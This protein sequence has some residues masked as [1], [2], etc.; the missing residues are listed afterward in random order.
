LEAD[1]YHQIDRPELALHY[2]RQALH[3][4]EEKGNQPM[5]AQAASFI[6]LELAQRHEFD[7]SQSAMQQAMA[8]LGQIPERQ[9]AYSQ[10]LVLLR[11][12]D[13]AAEQGK[14]EQAESRYAEAQRLAEN[15]EEQPLPLLK[16]LRAR[17]AS[18]ARVG[19]TE[20]AQADLKRAIALIERYRSGVSEQ[21]NRSDFF[22]ASQDVFDQMIQLEAHDSGQSI[23]A[24]NL[25]EQARARTLLDDLAAQANTLATPAP[26]PSS[27]AAQRSANPLTLAEIRRRLPADLTLLSY[28]V[29]RTGTLI[30]VVSRDTFE[31]KE[32]AATTDTLDRLVQG[33]VSSLKDR[34]SSEE[35]AEPSRRL[36]DLLIGP[37]ADRLGSARRLCIA[38]DK[39][40]HRLP[41]AALR[42]PSGNYLI[43]S[44]VL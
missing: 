36:Y 37:V 35:L 27:L 10:S 11:A 5:I 28:S 26:A 7:A 14:L 3:Y 43:Q 32:S 29:S 18:Y 2:A 39:A 15:G 16:V 40:L 42:S 41:F 34:S 20:K 38:P 4:A 8:A 24:F 1:F 9:R 19:N 44:Y 25:S 17:A 30:F 33:F 22:D 31:M 13:I 23:A 21:S 12:G 6:A